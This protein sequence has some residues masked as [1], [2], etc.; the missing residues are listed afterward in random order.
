[1]FNF[2]PDARMRQSEPASG[3]RAFPVM[4]EAVRIFLY[5]TL[6]RIYCGWV[7][8][9]D[10]LDPCWVIQRDLCTVCNPYRVA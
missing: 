7:Q 8:S 10:N 2:F 4:A 9:G 3:V 1:M 6:V 5:Y